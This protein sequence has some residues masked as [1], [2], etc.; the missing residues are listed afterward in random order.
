VK[1]KDVLYILIIVGLI[2][3]WVFSPGP[4]PV[5]KEVPVEVPVIVK[6]PVI[7]RKFDTIY[8]PGPTKYKDNEELVEQ[9]KALE[10]EVER[11][12]LLERAT[13]T[14]WYT[15]TYED[16]VQA[17]T[18][19]T[20][21]SGN[22]N[23]QNVSYETKPREIETVVRDTIPVPVEPRIHLRAGAEVG[24]PTNLANPGAV[25]KG[26]LY[27]ENKKGMIFSAGYDTQGR[28]WGGVIIKVF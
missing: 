24:V 7:E 8:K 1:A 19:N 20:Q 16:S 22:L 28:A 25:L 3:W 4:E 9:Y 6:V 18:V 14:Q 11:L 12:S 2:A 23:W 27:L 15:E 26:N 10:T 21:V 5:I 13:R 17:I